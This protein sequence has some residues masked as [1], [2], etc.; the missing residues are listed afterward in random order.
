MATCFSTSVVYHNPIP[1]I[2]EISFA[3][4]FRQVPEFISKISRVDVEKLESIS[5]VCD[6]N[7]PSKICL[8]EQPK[9]PRIFHQIWIGPKPVPEYL[10]RYQD[11][12]RKLHPDFEYHLWSEEALSTLSLPDLALVN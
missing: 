9:I 4:G 5:K 7:L 12:L 3:Y 8:S 2:Q 1:S 6:T 10:L 11:S